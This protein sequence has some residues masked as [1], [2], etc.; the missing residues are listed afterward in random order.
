MKTV[1]A[2]VYLL[3]VVKGIVCTVFEAIKCTKGIYGFCKKHCGSCC[4][5]FFKGCYGS[6]CKFFK[7]CCGSAVVSSLKSCSNSPVAAPA[8]MVVPETYNHT[9]SNWFS[10]VTASAPFLSLAVDVV[11]F[12]S[13]LV[14]A[15]DICALIFDRKTNGGIFNEQE[16][17]LTV[18]DFILNVVSNLLNYVSYNNSCCYVLC[19]YHQKARST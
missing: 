14:S 6:C 15:F 3:T 8:V 16:F 12:V 17:K 19:S 7:G 5:K 10:F 2:S 13:L 9:C 4:S 11:A 18:A 1:F